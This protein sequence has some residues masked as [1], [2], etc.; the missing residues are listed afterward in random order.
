MPVHVVTVSSAEQTRFA[1]AATYSGSVQGDALLVMKDGAVVYELYT[2]T[3]TASSAHLLASGTKSFDV[4]LFAMGEAMGIWTLD[5][6]VSHTITE[7]QGVPNS[8]HLRPE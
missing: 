2:G 6:N 4:A 8:L 7:W 3:T 5:E 1:D